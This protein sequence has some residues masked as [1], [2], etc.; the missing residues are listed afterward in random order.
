MGIAT[1]SVILLLM[2]LV[3]VAPG[4]PQVVD[5]PGELLAISLS[6]GCARAFASFSRTMVLRFFMAGTGPKEGAGGPPIVLAACAHVLCILFIMILISL[7][8]AAGGPGGGAQGVVAFTTGGPG[9]GPG[10]D[11][12]CEAWAFPRS[13]F[14]CSPTVSSTCWTTSEC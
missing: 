5:G 7:F 9:W 1:V 13:D 12:G 2:E 4:V 3:L 11:G 8:F 14:D 10:C 6:S